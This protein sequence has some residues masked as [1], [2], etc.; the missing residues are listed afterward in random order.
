M[1]K[2]DFDRSWIEKAKKKLQNRL[3]QGE[4]KKNLSYFVKR[5]LSQKLGAKLIHTQIWR[6]QV[7]GCEDAN[8]QTF[9]IKDEVN[10]TFKKTQA[11]YYPK[12]QINV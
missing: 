6:F 1:S 11:N 10:E 5:L 9:F 2:D 8:I 12:S 3:F 7:E 4:L